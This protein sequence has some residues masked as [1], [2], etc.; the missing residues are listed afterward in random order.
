MGV[1]AEFELLLA[2]LFDGQPDPIRNQ[3]LDELLQAHPELQDEYLAQVQMHAILQWRGGQ[4]A[5]PSET[6]APKSEPFTLVAS[7][8]RSF[9]ASLIVVAACVAVM[10]LWWTP[11]THATTDVME[12]LVDLNIDLTQARSRDERIR[13]FEAHAETLE[14]TLA[15]AELPPEDR[16]LA[17]A[18]LE[19]GRELAKEVNP[20]TE[21]VRFN[22]LADKLV[23]RLELANASQDER[24]MTQLLD[25]YNR[26]NEV[27]VKENLKLALASASIDADKKK[28][29]AGATT[30]HVARTHRVETMIDRNPEPA[31]RMFQKAMKGHFHKK[32]HK[33]PAE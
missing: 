3:R 19:N 26:V 25:A 12:Q 29:L 5:A 8:W 7:R 33:K 30:H 9:A 31:R 2:D 4:A 10:L 14:T 20:A 21:A 27:G 24:R 23:A 11:E 22:E 16:K 17:E 32:K 6:Q 1:R 28:K 13:I 18:L 15:S